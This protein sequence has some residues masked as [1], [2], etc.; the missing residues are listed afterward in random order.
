MLSP[1]LDFQVSFYRQK[2]S[3]KL[4]WGY[5]CRGLGMALLYFN[6]LNTLLEHLGNYHI[7]FNYVGNPHQICY[8]CYVGSPCLSW[9]PFHLM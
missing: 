5:R 4:D 7:C 9:F 6:F 2:H 8:S 3:F 1:R